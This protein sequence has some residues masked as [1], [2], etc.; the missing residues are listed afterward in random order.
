VTVLED[1]L[2]GELRAEGELITPE[3]IVPLRLPSDTE[4]VPGVLR[5]GG[6]RQWAPWL[7]PLAAAAAAAAVFAGTFAFAHMLLGSGQG[8]RPAGPKY[9]TVPANYAYTV[10]GDIYHYKS[11]GTQYSAS[12]GGRYLKVRSTAT[13]KLLATVFPPKPYNN[14]SMITADASGTVFVLAAVHE[15]QRYANAL[16]RV[17]R[18]NQTTP[19]RFL[20][21]RIG[22]AGQVQQSSLSLPVTVTPKQQPSIALS[23]EGTRLAVAYGGGGQPAQVAVVTLESMQMRR[24]V[25][26]RVPWTPQLSYQGAWAADGRTLVLQRWDVIRNPSRQAVLHRRPPMT[27]QVTLIDTLAPGG[28][29]DAG[30]FLALRPRAGE[31]PPAD[32]F[33]TPDG[34]KLIGGTSDFPPASG[35]WTGELSVYS[36]RTGAL[37][38]RLGPWKWN[39]SDRRP[40][41][42][43]SPRELVAWSNASGSR[44]ILLYPLDD[45]NILGVLTGNRFSPAG[46]PLPR[47]SGY[48]ELEYALRTAGQMVW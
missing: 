14:F 37:L 25:S 20:E 45:L 42:G 35:P 30:R 10:Q 21:L 46:A 36:A 41:H 40:G 1:R 32:V 7:I 38:Q 8:P 3:G 44:L 2:R 39:G 6:P 16:P 27:T 24:W 34:T 18:R 29:L 9:A 31:S 33:I 22:S 4:P 26:P 17:Y 11:H 47:A 12:V 28:T 23:P 5:R 15:W 13:G 19:L 43:G 48:Q